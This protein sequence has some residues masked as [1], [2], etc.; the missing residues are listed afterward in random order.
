MLLTSRSSFLLVSKIVDLHPVIVVFSVIV[1]SQYL[2]LVGM[3]ISI[4]C[5]AAVK[6]ITEV[7]FEEFY[8]LI[9]TQK[10]GI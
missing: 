7:M 3:I 6:L 10:V 4:P 9:L 8:L 5:A 2:G 1:G